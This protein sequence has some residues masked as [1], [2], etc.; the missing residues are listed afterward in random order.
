MNE[1][2]LMKYKVT[3]DGIDIEKYMENCL[4]GGHQFLLKDGNKFEDFARGRTTMRIVRAFEN[5][6]V[7]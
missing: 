2:E 6:H 5:F 1:Y 7:N 4:L 3:A